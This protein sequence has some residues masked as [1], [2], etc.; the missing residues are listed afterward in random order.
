MIP[1]ALL[2][3]LPVEDLTIR[4]LGLERVHS[5]SGGVFKEKGFWV[6]LGS[7]EAPPV[8]KGVRSFRT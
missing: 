6:K 7:A 4:P 5:F 8:Y 2:G 3:V 1:G